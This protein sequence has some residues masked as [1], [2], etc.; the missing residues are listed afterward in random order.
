MSQKTRG[1]YDE[2][3][4]SPPIVNEYKQKKLRHARIRWRGYKVFTWIAT[5]SVGILCILNEDISNMHGVE[6]HV[7][8]GVR[9]SPC[10]PSPPCCVAALEE[11]SSEVGSHTP[12]FIRLSQIY[13]VKRELFEAW[14]MDE[15]VFP[16]FQR[17]FT[18]RVVTEFEE[19]E[20]EASDEVD[21]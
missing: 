5:V 6:D 14:A 10:G 19:P 3:W 21:R 2:R 17:A 7:F 12:T 4:D 16:I 1:V 9:C 18:T 20:E 13:R 15:P 11:S 8:S